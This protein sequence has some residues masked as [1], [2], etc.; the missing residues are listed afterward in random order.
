MNK[1]IDDLIIEDVAWFEKL[2][3]GKYRTLG[4]K[5]FYYTFLMERAD[6]SINGQ[7][8]R[9]AAE[10]FLYYQEIFVYLL[11]EGILDNPEYCLDWVDIYGGTTFSL[12]LTKVMKDI[13][14]EAKLNDHFAERGM[15]E[16][17]QTLCHPADSL[18]CGI[19]GSVSLS[20]HI[21]FGQGKDKI[22]YC[23]ACHPL[24]EN[25]KEKIKKVFEAEGTIPAVAKRLEFI[26]E[27]SK[28]KMAEGYTIN[29]FIYNFKAENEINPAPKADAIQKI[30]DKEGFDYF[31]VFETEQGIVLWNRK[32][33]SDFDIFSK[34]V[35]LNSEGTEIIVLFDHAGVVYAD[36]K[37][38][39]FAC[40][41]TSDEELIKELKEN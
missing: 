32:A 5:T 39:D 13:D 36:E 10:D 31:E 21:S 2:G 23:L 30:I 26:E 34:C 16:Y 24:N 17:I 35:T 6:E 8:N 38:I 22:V 11:N 1:K 3:D 37:A 20:R 18:R 4:D 29:M 9:K 12:N 25:C 15:S 19:C 40:H 33:L 14:I 7:N 27:A 28:P 41:M